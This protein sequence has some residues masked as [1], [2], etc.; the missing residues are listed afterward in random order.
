MQ[1]PYFQIWSN[2]ECQYSQFRR[3]WAQDFLED[4]VPPLADYPSINIKNLKYLNVF[5]FSSDTQ[6]VLYIP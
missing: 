3:I 6:F 5:F 2:L 1:W 4:T